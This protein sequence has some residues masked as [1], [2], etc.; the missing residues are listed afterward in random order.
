MQDIL[1]LGVHAFAMSRYARR[2][3]GMKTIQEIVESSASALIDPERVRIALPT[4]FEMPPGGVH[5]RWPDARC[6]RRSACGPSGMRPW[7][8]CAPT[9]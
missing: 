4:D 3:A 7:P 8:M 6:R 9:A 2:V 5:I 1:D